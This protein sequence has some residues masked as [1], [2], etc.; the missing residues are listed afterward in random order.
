MNEVANVMSEDSVVCKLVGA[1]VKGMN[2]RE[3]CTLLI[4]SHVSR[5]TVDRVPCY[6]T[7]DLSILVMNPARARLDEMLVSTMNVADLVL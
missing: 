1:T 2:P 6:S 3:T 7:G 5:W 4:E